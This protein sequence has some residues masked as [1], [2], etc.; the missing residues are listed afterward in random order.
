M[1]CGCFQSADDRSCEI[2]R[3]GHHR[4]SRVARIDAKGGD[5]WHLA[6]ITMHGA[7]DAP[8]TLAMNDADL[9]V[10]GKQ[11][12]VDQLLDQRDGIGGGH[13]VQIQRWCRSRRID[14]VRWTSQARVRGVPFPGLL[15]RFEIAIP[16]DDD[17]A[18]H[19]D[20][21]ASRP[22]CFDDHSGTQPAQ[23][24]TI[25]WRIAHRSDCRITRMIRIVCAVVTVV[26]LSA[27]PLAQ[28]PAAPAPTDRTRA[29]VY[30]AADLAAAIA[31]LP[32]D[33]PA[34]SVR[35][36]TLTPYNVAV[37]RRLPREQGASLH[38]AQAELFYVIDGSATLLTGGKL[39]GE[40]RN[41][42][43]LSGKGIEGGVR[44]TF[45]KGDFLLVPSGIAH[46]FVDIKAPIQL[47][48]IYLPN[49]Q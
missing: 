29:H 13:A 33:R 4:H 1:I 35:V 21:I 22:A 25:A 32:T 43:N 7:F 30:S 19:L 36:F 37:E 49:A 47:M 48:S 23:V 17:A 14:S 16:G 8:A 27:A 40:T 11:R 41:G 42:S 6:Q 18:L 26:S 24:D 44:Q 34:S 39:V 5:A 20:G 31:K 15:R 3:E 9:A 2:L 46:Q 28:A 12:V 10:S 38:E 45:G